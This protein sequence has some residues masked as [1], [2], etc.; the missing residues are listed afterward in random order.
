MFQ[1]KPNITTIITTK[2]P[3]PNNVPVNV[4]ITITTHS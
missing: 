1:T 3:K 4:V 2:N